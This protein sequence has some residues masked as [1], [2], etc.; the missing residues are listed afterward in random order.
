MLGLYK[1][2]EAFFEGL[3][4]PV[5]KRSNKLDRRYIFRCDDI[6]RD[7]EPSKTTISALKDS[8]STSIARAWLQNYDP[9]G[10]FPLAVA[11]REC[12]NSWTVPTRQQMI[13]IPKEALMRWKDLAAEAGAKVSRFDLVASWIHVVSFPLNSP[14]RLPGSCRRCVLYRKATSKGDPWLTRKK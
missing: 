10:L 9:S 3:N 8:M 14:N 4:G 12:W 5:T 6:K 13:R 2:A 11:G 1:A 7:V